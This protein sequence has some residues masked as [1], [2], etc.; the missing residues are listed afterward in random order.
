MRLTREWL[1]AE[2][3]RIVVDAG[4]EGNRI[5]LVVVEEERRPEAAEAVYWA[6][7]FHGPLDRDGIYRLVRCIGD[8]SEAGHHLIVVWQEFPDHEEATVVALLRHEVEHAAQW[9]RHGPTLFDDLDY[10]V[11]RA[12]EASG[13]DYSERP[14]ERAA[15]D[16]ARDYV[17]RYYGDEGVASAAAALPWGDAEEGARQM[18]VRQEMDSALREW[19]PPGHQIEVGQC[20]TIGVEEFLDQLGPG[21][22]LRPSPHDEESIVFLPCGS[23]VAHR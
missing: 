3:P 6:P 10:E 9:E 4:I 21:R 13:H 19:A 12:G 22:P 8:R 16:A 5:Q 20:R 23:A 7:S 18:N 2:W 15:N 1:E 14:T 11:R 17:R